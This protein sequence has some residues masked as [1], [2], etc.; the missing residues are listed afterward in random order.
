MGSSAPTPDLTAVLRSA[1]RLQNLVPGAVLVGGA[2]AAL[3]AGHRQSFDHDHVLTDL[4]QRYEDVVEAV[5]ASGGWVTSVRAS[6]PPL[7]LLGSLDGIEAGLRQLRRIR[8]LEVEEIRLVSGD[9]VRV[10][11][12]REM[13]RVKTYL[14]VQR[15]V[16][17]DYLD[18]VA[19]ADRLGRDDAVEV[20]LGLDQYY[21]DRS[22]GDDSVLTAA[23]QRLSE[24]SPRDSRTTR[25]LAAYKGLA[26][27]W[28][29][30][31][32]VVAAAQ[33][34]ADGIVEALEAR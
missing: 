25:Q 8:P 9:T 12:H 2:A 1:A 5:Q 30:W 14:V 18:T 17:R 23:V 16:V 6:S 33:A 20:L 32:A 31:P 28:H 27:R 22:G 11:P 15:N 4:A 21:A 19:L 13:L 3:H 26:L 29:E 34:L 10:P 24:P 7:T